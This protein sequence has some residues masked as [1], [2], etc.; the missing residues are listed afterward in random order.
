M[1]FFKL[2]RYFNYFYLKN[3]DVYENASVAFELLY[4]LSL[5]KEESQLLSLVFMKTTIQIISTP[6]YT[7]I[8]PDQIEMGDYFRTIS[9]K[10]LVG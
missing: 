2:F 5:D 8:I 6:I 9:I 7:F 1:I 4:F 3:N 10:S